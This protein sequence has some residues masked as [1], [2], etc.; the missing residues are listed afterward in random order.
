MAD[1]T[2]ADSSVVTKDPL[3]SLAGQLRHASTGT[4]ARLR[5]SD[6]S[7]NP[8]SALFDT[9]RLLIAAGIQ[10]QGEERERWALLVHCLA[11]AQG[12]HD[13]RADAEPGKV[14]HQLR[15]SE[16]RLQQLIEADQ[17]L[18]FALLPRLAR[19][20]AVAGRSVNWWPLAH[21]LLGTGSGD[22]HREDQADQARQRLARHYVNA[23]GLAEAEELQLSAQGD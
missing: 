16:A 10:V 15:F 7:K 22:P 9:E 19:R 14:L 11:L 5:R 13:A 21:L 17:P 3:A 2:T 8:R 6:P 20:L 4:L 1:M 12:Q 18:L 23:Q